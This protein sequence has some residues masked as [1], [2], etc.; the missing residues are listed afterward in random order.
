MPKRANDTRSPRLLVTESLHE[1]SVWPMHSDDG[2]KHDAHNGEGDNVS[3]VLRP[4]QG[5]EEF[6]SDRLQREAGENVRIS[7]VLHHTLEPWPPNHPNTFWA[8]CGKI[9]TA[10]VSLS[11]GPT[12]PPSVYINQSTIFVAVFSVHHERTAWSNL[13]PRR[14]CSAAIAALHP[15]PAGVTA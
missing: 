9:T 2:H 15:S 4:S 12:T 8:P 10:R 5:A 7:D 13:K 14:Y 3:K 1:E 11:I 6:C